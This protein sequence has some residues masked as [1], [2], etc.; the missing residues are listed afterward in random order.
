MCEGIVDFGVEQGADGSRIKQ[1]PD[2]LE[3]RIPSQHETDD[4]FHSSRTQ[5]RA[6]MLQTS[7]VQSHG[8]FDN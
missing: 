6:K 3:E 2:Q 1:R 4:R 8:L 5:R 7:K